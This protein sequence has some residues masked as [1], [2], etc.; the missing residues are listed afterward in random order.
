MAEKKITA[1]ALAKQ[2]GVNR[3]TVSNWSRADEMPRFKDAATTLNQ[4]CHFLDCSLQDL[5]EYISDESG[6]GNE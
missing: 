5:A 6:S 4:L 3:V 2:L 1:T